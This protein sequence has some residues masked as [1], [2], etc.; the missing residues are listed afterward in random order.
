MEEAPPDR[1]PE[2]PSEREATPLAGVVAT[3]GGIVLLAIL[4]LAIDPLRSGIGDA[5]TGNT[6]QLRGDLR[7]L[8]VGGALITL[9]LALAHVVV[10][11]PA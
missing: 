7:G 10:W 11:Y 5:V 8:G 9:M 3:I 4:I 1:G 6:D 2:P